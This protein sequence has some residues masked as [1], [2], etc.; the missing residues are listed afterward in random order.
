M[1][2]ALLS[3]NQDTHPW[4]KEKAINKVQFQ[5]FTL[6]E[7]LFPAA[8]SPPI[9]CSTAGTAAEP[10]MLFFADLWGLIGNLTTLILSPWLFLW[11]VWL[12]YC[13][14]SFRFNLKSLSG[15]VSRNEENCRQKGLLFYC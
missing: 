9:F 12:Q 3:A 14:N 15:I 4:L 1:Q 5:I 11:A 10:C 8:A 13:F 6:P 7:T 2:R